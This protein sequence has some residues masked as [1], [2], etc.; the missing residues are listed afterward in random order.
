M[1]MK[2]QFI[3]DFHGECYP[4][5][6]WLPPLPDEN[7]CDVLVLAGDISSG[8][9]TIAK[10]RDIAH[11]VP[12]TQV[13][14]VSGN[15]DF[16]GVEIS[17]QI[18]ECRAAF[19]L[20]DRVHFLENSSVT[21][22][23]VRFLGAT[24]WSGFDVLGSS[25]LRSAM[26]VAGENISDFHLIEEHTPNGT[27]RFTPVSMAKRYEESR[28]WLSEE[29]KKGDLHKTVVV[30]HFPPCRE[31]RH[32]GFPEGLLT[33]YFVA[34][35]DDLVKQYQPAAWIYGHNHWSSDF[36]VGRCRM[37]SNQLGYPP[38]SGFIP[39]CDGTKVISF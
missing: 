28:H 13:I 14:F 15:H 24:L 2:I 19:E 18:Q 22:G 39:G 30:T 35:C 10:V 9:N 31:A 23:G 16:Y 27:Q 21:I 17:E 11:A 36:N 3:S 7:E 4:E 33:C 20:D 1:N 8:G 6:D 26:Q 32:P 25:K 5:P 37:V 12:K 38:E 34:N 29:L